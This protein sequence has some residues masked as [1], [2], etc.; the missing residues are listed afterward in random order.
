MRRRGPS[1]EQKREKEFRLKYNQS[2]KKLNGIPSRLGEMNPPA[3]YMSARKFA[4]LVITIDA[5]LATASP[6][7]SAIL[8]KDRE[9]LESQMKWMR[10]FSGFLEEE[11]GRQ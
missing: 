1:R 7:E 2:L 9:Y 8:L 5:R 6:E 3:A 10:E 4:Q 11:L